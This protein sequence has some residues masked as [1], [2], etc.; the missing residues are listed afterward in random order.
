ML[1]DIELDL[2]DMVAQGDKVVTRYTFR[3]RHTGDFMGVQ[4]THRRVSWSGIVIDRFVD[5]RIVEAWEIF[6]RYGLMQQ[7]GA[8]GEAE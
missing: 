1:S 7:L 3:A 5:G 8:L 6:D 4:A 2:D